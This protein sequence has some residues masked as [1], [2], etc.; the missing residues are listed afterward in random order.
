MECF[1]LILIL[2]YIWIVGA[3]KIAMKDLI[4]IIEKN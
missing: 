4:G 2:A 3:G 1:I